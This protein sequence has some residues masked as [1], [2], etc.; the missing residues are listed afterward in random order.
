MTKTSVPGRAAQWADNYSS[1]R[2]HTWEY[3][4]KQCGAE[5]EAGGYHP[6]LAGIR[7]VNYHP[8]TGEKVSTGNLRYQNPQKGADGKPQKFK[9]P[10]GEPNLPYF[11]PSLDW[12]KAFRDTS[13]ELI[14][15]EGETRSIAGAMH[16]FHIIALGGIDG[17][18]EPKSDSIQSR[19]ELR[20]ILKKIV[21]KGRRVIIIPDADA[22]ANKRVETAADALA[23][24]LKKRGAN[25]HFAKVPEW[26]T[27]DGK[28]G[29]DDLLACEGGATNLRRICTNAKKW[30]DDDAGAVP[31]TQ[32]LSEVESEK[33]DWVWEGRI[34]RG[35]V[36]MF[37]GDPG[38]AKTFVTM[39]VAADLTRGRIPASGAG[40]LKPLCVLYA[41]CEN[42][43]SHVIG[44]RFRAMG[45][46][47]K[48][49]I[50]LD[51]A[52]DAAGN[53]AGITFS[54]LAPVERAIQKHKADL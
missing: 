33:V 47:D 19:S 21:W 1:A 17:G 50:L 16:G 41:S 51:G 5:L 43:A 31:V 23:G 8:L 37:S 4:E 45:G 53:S 12:K 36:T 10:A 13:I 11:A 30:S 6:E 24:L 20:S 42:S 40:K 14:I 22:D 27:E 49:L 34:A 25:V 9:R 2:G 28:A 35:E 54:N 26:I 32:P 39:S 3:A 44:P 48:K 29:I 38:S 18:F 15:T 7:Y 52:V 46:D